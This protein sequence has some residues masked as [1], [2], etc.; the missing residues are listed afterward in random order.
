MTPAMIDS[1]VAMEERFWDM[2]SAAKSRDRAFLAPE[3]V[4]TVAESPPL[5]DGRAAERVGNIL[6][7]AVCEAH[8]SVTEGIY[9]G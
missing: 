3:Q 5:R 2:K 4:R 8:S 6:A 1:L 7:T 9:H